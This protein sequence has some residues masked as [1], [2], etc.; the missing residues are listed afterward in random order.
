VP[1]IAPATFEQLYKEHGRDVYRFAVYLCGDPQWAEDLTSD[2]FLR[3]WTSPIP[4]R[5]PTVKSYL[6]TIVRNLIAEESHR[7]A[8]RPVAEINEQVLAGG[9]MVRET[10][11]RNE[12]AIVQSALARLPELS[13]LALLLKSEGG[14]S[15]DEIAVVLEIPA[16]TARVR[17]HRARLELAKAIGKEIMS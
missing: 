10:E 7:R 8:R 13:R 14:L 6:L 17:V 4:V 9:S 15:Y 5:M 1:A 16:V 3:V 11:A 2:A 12:L